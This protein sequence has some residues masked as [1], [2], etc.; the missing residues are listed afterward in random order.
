MR[1]AQD[2]AAK[3]ETADDAVK[4]LKTATE[5]G[6]HLLARAV[7]GHA[8]AQR[9]RGV[10]ADYAETTGLTDDL[11]ELN[12][13]PSGGLLATA[14]TALFRVPTPPELQPG[15]GDISDAQMRRLADGEDLS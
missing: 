11:D 14:M 1:D 7:A 15:I 13:I 8:H 2:R 12:A 5:M 10:T 9:W 3:L 4:M 6:D